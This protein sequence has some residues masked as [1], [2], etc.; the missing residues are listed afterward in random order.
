MISRW[1][2]AWVAALVSGFLLVTAGCEAEGSSTARVG[3]PASS[4]PSSTSTDPTTRDGP[5]PPSGSSS[6]HDP[7]SQLPRGGETIFPHDRVVAYYGTAGSD[8]LGVLGSK[9][10]EQIASEI[11]KAA[12]PY[13]TPGEQVLPAMELVVTVADAAPGPDGNYSHDIATS[14]VRRYEQAAKKNH[15]LLILD[16]Q[17]GQ[18]PFLP[19]VKHWKKLLAE[20]N[21]GLALDSEW[22]MPDGNTPGQVT[23]HADAANINKV[24]SWLAT[25]TDRDHLPQKLFIFHQFTDPMIRH[26]DDINTPPELAVI[27]Q[28][29]GFGTQHLKLSKWKKLKHPKR[30]H[31]GF[32]LFYTQDTD[33]MSPKQVLALH[34]P[35]DYISY[36]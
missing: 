27:Q 1:R 28:L 26:I 29:D 19:L 33:L 18:S 11:E 16:I 36:E 13:N 35:P 4:S 34:P 7:K 15:M 12:A 22:H 5:T 25:L 30:F 10:P 14:K 9:P 21:V 20:P 32:K 8:A 6:A 2:R 17:P 23:G 24:S 31:M 3:T